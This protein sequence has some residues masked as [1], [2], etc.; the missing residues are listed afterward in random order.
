[1][2]LHYAFYSRNISLFRSLL[3]DGERGT[4]SAGS[5][6]SKSNKGPSVL[7]AAMGCDVNSFDWLGRTALHLACA[8]PD[9]L[10]YVRALLKH[11]FVNANLPDKESHYTPLHRAMY[12]GN[13][14]AALLLLQRS[15]IDT[16]LK[17]FEGHTAFDLYNSTVN[18]TAPRPSPVAELY[19][20]GVNRNAALGQ[21]SGDRSSPESVCIPKVGPEPTSTKRFLPLR[22][23]QISMAKLHTV[24]VTTERKSNLRVCGFGSGG[25]LGPGQQTQYRLI[26]VP[27]S[28]STEVTCVALGQDHTLA[29]TSNGEVFSWGLSRFHQ[30]GYTVEPSPTMGKLEEPVQST[31]RRIFGALKKE[32]VK[33]IAASKQSSACFTATEV[34]T[35][36]TNNGQLGYDKTAQPFQI[37]PRKVSKISRPVVA[38]ALNDHAMA[39]LLDTQEVFC[40]WNDRCFKINFPSHAFPSEIQPYRPPQAKLDAH[41]AKI[42]SSDDTIAALSSNG[43]LFTF[44]IPDPGEAELGRS[45]AFKP[46]RV[47]A[48]RKQF[49]AV[50]DVALGADG[51]IIICTE[52]GN[53]FVRTRNTKGASTNKAFKFQRVPYIQR[54]VQVCANNAGA[55]GALRVDSRPTPIRVEGNTIVEDLTAIQPYSSSPPPKLI[56]DESQQAPETPPSMFAVEDHEEAEESSIEADFAR[57]WAFCRLLKTGCIDPPRHGADVLVTANGK[58]FPAHRVILAARCKAFLS[59]LAGNP[60][61]GD[62]ITI[63]P[64]PITGNTGIKLGLDFQGCAPM[65]IL[66]LLHYLYSDDLLAI[67]DGRIVSALQIELTTHNIKPAQVKL[68]LQHLARLLEM[69]LLGEALEAQAKRVPT[70]SLGCDLKELFCVCQSH[71]N[72]KSAIAPD[73]ILQLADR[74]VSCHS[75]ILRSR[76]PVFSG[77]FDEA[78]WTAK[79]RDSNGVVKINL[80]HLRWS[81]M[82]YVLQYMLCGVESEMF[83]H[84]AFANSVDDALDFMFEVMAIAVI[85]QYRAFNSAYIIQDELMLDRLV[86]LCSEVILKWTD[87]NH[88]CF[89]LAEA[90]YYHAEQ[91]VDS[92]Q[93]Y[94]AENLETFLE[95]SMLND[96]TPSLIKQLSHFVSRRQIEKSP[97][98]RTNFVIERAMTLHGDWLA[99]QDIAEPIPLSTKGAGRKPPSSPELGPKRRRSGILSNSAVMVPQAPSTAMDEIF[100]IDDAEVAPPKHPAPVWKASSVP[101]VDMKSVM[102]EAVQ[103]Q[104]PTPKPGVALSSSKSANSSSWKVSTQSPPITPSTSLGRPSGEAFPTLVPSTPPW[105]RPPQTTQTGLGPIF[106]PHSTNGPLNSASTSVW[107][108]TGGTKAWTQP[109]LAPVASSSTATAS[110]ASFATIQQL[111]LEQELGASVGRDKKSLVDIQAEEEFLKW[112]A[113]EEQRVKAEADADAAAIARVLAG[114]NNGSAN[115]SPK[116]TRRNRD[117]GNERSQPRPITSTPRWA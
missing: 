15:D 86:L 57:L 19:T 18:G 78:D 42:T 101:K 1:M 97:K 55:F 23:R 99:L 92:V 13:I 85:Q 61:R 47:W 73:V 16:S 79:R 87:I 51:T 12:H 29:L 30:L 25:R 69:T 67:W 11:P 27:I 2:S 54:V 80:K 36:G 115:K 96:L 49:S 76:S 109:P 89:I 105:Q 82:D 98:A 113:E 102:A 112:W 52:S 38:I 68:E 43:E 66:I 63:K 74:D 100:E 4:H 3:D 32:I 104:A 44:S 90:S 60:I 59:V 46:Q 70:P 10:E 117:K 116:R 83:E 111:Q 107:H 94:I 34:F 35:W 53:V 110:V 114:E 9:A 37:L 41:I 48:L 22:V 75:A 40:V 95:C 26:P 58:E 56:E 91:L 93:G 28:T 17:D 6:R 14:A 45:H 21:D 33:G 103:S 77:F 39:C 108:E 88:A 8:A 65:T 64:V 81:V 72:P 31:P 20:W 71:V 106:T 62:R 50:R 24:V 5:P 7:K 84:L